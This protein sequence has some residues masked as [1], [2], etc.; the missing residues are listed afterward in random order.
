MLHT[1]CVATNV[2]RWPR[3]NALPQRASAATQC[4]MLPDDTQADVQSQ[5]TK[6]LADPAIRLAVFLPPFRDPSPS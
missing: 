3:Q 6:A 1:T 5:L 2:V 4:R